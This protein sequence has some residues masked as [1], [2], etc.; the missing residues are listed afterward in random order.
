[1]SSTSRAA[2]PVW[3]QQRAACGIPAPRKD[4]VVDE[5][6]VLEARAMGAELRPAPSLPRSSP[7]PASTCRPCSVLEALALGLGM[8]VLI[9]VHDGDELDIALQMRSPWSASTT[10]TCA[11]S[12]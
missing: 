4:F 7:A 12:R 1:M 10:A 11:A 6:Q 3:W 9:E 5:A 8:S 2:G